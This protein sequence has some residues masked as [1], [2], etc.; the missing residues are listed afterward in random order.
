MAEQHPVEII[1]LRQAA[2][3]LTIPI[4]ITNHDGD[5]IYYNDPAGKMVGL[6]FDEVGPLPV[7]QLQT[8]FKVT[9]FEGNP[10]TGPEVPTV[11]PLVTHRPARGKIRFLAL[12]QVWRDIEVW[13]TPLEA[14]SGRFVGILATFWELQD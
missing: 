9:D 7:D 6:E 5:L 12:D 10:L 4:W 8:M 3:Y 11:T 14:Q 1:L 13:A 2:S